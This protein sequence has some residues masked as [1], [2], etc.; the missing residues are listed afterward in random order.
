MQS[1]LAE[2]AN[3]SD[4]AESESGSSGDDSL[5]FDTE[6]FVSGTKA[7]R[8]QSRHG[9]GKVAMY[10]HRIVP[11]LPNCPLPVRLHFHTGG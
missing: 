3:E 4:D 2:E 6:T 5:G 11:Q 9:G 7:R 1:T 10:V 8:W